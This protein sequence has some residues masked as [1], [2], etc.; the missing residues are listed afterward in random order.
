MRSVDSVVLIYSIIYSVKCGQCGVNIQHYM[1]VMCGQ[2][3]VNI[4]HYMCV[5][6]GRCSVN[7][8]HYM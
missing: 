7:I 2:C 1:C 6:C 5:M 3:G 4:Q 8:Q